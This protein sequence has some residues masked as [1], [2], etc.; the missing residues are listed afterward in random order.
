MGFLGAM[1]FNTNDLFLKSS[2]IAMVL[3]KKRFIFVK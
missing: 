2:F 1:I 3:H